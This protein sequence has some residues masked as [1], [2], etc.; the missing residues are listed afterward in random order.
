[1]FCWLCHK[2]SINYQHILYS[3]VIHLRITKTFLYARHSLRVLVAGCEVSQVE[4]GT[5]Q[6]TFELTDENTMIVRNLTDTDH[7]MTIDND[8]TSFPF[9]W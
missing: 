8:R 2:E 7:R 9:Y 6:Y 4:I 1:M 5:K 3:I